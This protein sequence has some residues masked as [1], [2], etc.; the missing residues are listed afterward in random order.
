MIRVLALLALL[1]L[2]LFAALPTPQEAL[3]LAFPGAHLTR[4]EHVLT[5]A[6]AARV[7][8]LADGDLPGRWTVIYEARKNGGLMGI[9]CFDTHR[10]RTLNET[11]LVA[12]SPEG[13]ILRVEAVAFREPAEYRAKEAWVKQF[14]GRTLDPQLSL[15]GAIRPLSGATLTAHA[16]TDAARRCLALHQV[17]YRDAQ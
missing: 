1:A 6:Q 7:K 15:K 16:M 14:E 4:K 5:E 10:V 13:R 8:A 11:L 9:G 3:A 17:L 12:I 2:P